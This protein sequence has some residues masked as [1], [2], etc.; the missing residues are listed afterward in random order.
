MNRAGFRGPSDEAG[1]PIV[2]GREMHAC[3]YH[4]PGLGDHCPVERCGGG[5]VFGGSSSHG[6]AGVP[7]SRTVH[8]ARIATSA[9]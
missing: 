6:V 7:V 1:R 9:I 2:R 8:G 4:R 5:E 3:D